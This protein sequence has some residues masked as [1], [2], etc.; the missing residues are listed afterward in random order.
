MSYAEG[1]LEHYG[2]EPSNPY[3][4]SVSSYD[5]V[6]NF[7]WFN[8]GYHQE[9]HWDPKKHWTRM[10]EL[11]EQIKYQLERNRTRVLTGPHFT[12]LL[13]DWLLKRKPLEKLPPPQSRQNRAA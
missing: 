3:A 2:A 10:P 4:N 11:H 12:A 7:L 8:N 13:E 6:Y 5:P 1:Y 9:H